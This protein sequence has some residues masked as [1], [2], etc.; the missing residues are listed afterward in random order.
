MYSQ[1][2]H[3]V[4]ISIVDMLNKEIR[5]IHTLYNSGL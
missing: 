3:I 5:P 4:L 2:I 1:L